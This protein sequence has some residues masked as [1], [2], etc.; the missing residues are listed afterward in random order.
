[1]KNLANPKRILMC[2]SPRAGKRDL[3]IALARHLG[4]AMPGLTKTTD[5]MPQQVWWPVRFPQGGEVLLEA[6][7]GPGF[8]Y[9]KGVVDLFSRPVAGV[10]YVLKQEN[11]DY[12]ESWLD[13]EQSTFDTY[14]EIANQ[15]R[16]GYHEV[17]WLFVQAR[18]WQPDSAWLSEL[19][20]PALKSST[21]TVDAASGA[22]IPELA[23]AIERMLADASPRL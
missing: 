5:E 8:T 12:Y 14:Y 9:K 20:P 7:H 21:L 16:C 23:H 4:S 1:M 10:I 22:G 11:R 17:P 6:L 13:L 19:I 15:T 3:M 2:G 18:N